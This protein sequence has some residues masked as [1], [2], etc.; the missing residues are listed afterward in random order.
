MFLGQKHLN[1][2]IT[3]GVINGTKWPN[4]ESETNGRTLYKIWN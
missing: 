2:I 3:C 1:D 4:Q